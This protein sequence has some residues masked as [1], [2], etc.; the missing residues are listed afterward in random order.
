MGSHQS[1]AAGDRRA[2]SSAGRVLPRAAYQGLLAALSEAVISANRQDHRH[3]VVYRRHELVGRAGNDGAG[4]K[5]IPRFAAPRR[6][7]TGKPERA[8]GA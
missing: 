8:A 2:A 5:A 1:G 7:D 4:D 3:P 6:P